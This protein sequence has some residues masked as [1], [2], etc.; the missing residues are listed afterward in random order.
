MPALKVKDEPDTAVEG[1]LLSAMNSTKGLEFRCV[2]LAVVTASRRGPLRH[3]GEV[4]PPEIDRFQ[5]TAT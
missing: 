3:R 1:V 2:A 5:P 4:T